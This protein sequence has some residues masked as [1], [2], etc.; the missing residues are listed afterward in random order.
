[1]PIA[2]PTIRLAGLTASALLLACTIGPKTNPDD[3]GE[4]PASSS[5][6]PTGSASDDP[7]GETPTTGATQSHPPPSTSMEATTAMPTSDGPGTGPADDT[8][9]FIAMPDIGGD[10]V[11]CDLAGQDCGRGE[12]CNPSGLK[13]Q[14]SIFQGIPVCVPLVPDAK[15]PGEPCSVLGE[16]LDGTDDCELGAV[17]L[18]PDERGIGECH[19]MCN[20]E[21]SETSPDPTCPPGDACVGLACQ[22]CFWSYCDAPCDPRDPGTCDA[23]EVCFPSGDHWFCN[24]DASGDEGQ[25]GDPCEFINTCDPGLFCATPETLPD[26]N[27]DA[28]G[29]CTPF[30]ST[31][32]PNTCPGKAQ[33][34]VC[35]PWFA[36]DPPPELATLG[37]CALPQ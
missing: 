33:G 2:I 5:G 29:C 16:W 23:G 12:K 21:S 10:P 18:W 1:M 22:S 36:N 6:D 3:T 37:L 14:S 31:D 13:Q 17:C 32:K 24:L 9:G 19:A 28:S 11:A 20:I 8:S 30:C 27:T 4:T 25:D 26:C 15:K 34:E 35:V 7:T